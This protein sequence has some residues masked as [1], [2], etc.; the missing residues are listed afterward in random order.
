MPSMRPLHLPITQDVRRL[1]LATTQIHSVSYLDQ[2]R[3][4][5]PHRLLRE[6]CRRQRREL[7]GRVTPLHGEQQTAWT[8][9]RTR[10]QRKFRKAAECS[11]DHGFERLGG[12]VLIN[13]PR[14]YLNVVE[15]KLTDNLRDE[16]G[17]LRR[18][19]EQHEVE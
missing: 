1:S 17:L 16:A 8:Q 4:I 11:R 9:Q 7:L 3:H 19:V 13:A 15:F 18:A 12:M 14:F 10:R 2:T 6:V 5:E